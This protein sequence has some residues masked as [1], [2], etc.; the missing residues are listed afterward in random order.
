M[1]IGTLMVFMLYAGAVFLQPLALAILIFTLIV[2]VSDRIHGF[3]PTGRWTPRWLCNLI[4]IAV[5]VS[6]IAAISNVMASQ[7][8]QLARALPGY[9]EQLNAML[10]RLDVWLGPNNVAFLQNAIDGID[11]SALLMGAVGG[12]RSVL[13]TTVLVAIYVGFMM[14]ERRTLLRRIRIVTQDPGMGKNIERMLASISHSL[15]RYVGVKTFVS[16]LTGGVSYPIF[17][18]LGLDFAETW[19]VLTFALNFIP[20]IGSIIAIIFPA[21]VAL[22]QFD[23][24]GPFLIVVVCCGTLQFL[25]GN[26]LDPMLLGR[27]LN[28]STLMVILALTFWTSVW[29]VL[30]AFLSVPLTVCLMIVFSHMPATRGVAVLM[31]IDGRLST[32]PAAKS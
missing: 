30:G 10:Q 1:I 2:A 3:D 21:I 7:V 18:L 19:A 23:T 14:A 8:T 4:G 5:V 11:M 29:G 15:Q 22:I 12:A 16:I 27:S 31:S 26:L 17:L 20:S 24:I 32:E 25:L 13:T 9:E 28:L 6:G